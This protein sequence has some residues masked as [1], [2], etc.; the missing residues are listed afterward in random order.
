VPFTLLACNF[1]IPPIRLLSFSGGCGGG[2]EGGWWGWWWGG[3]G[4]GVGVEVLGG[5]GGSV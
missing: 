2:R 3:W 4:G 5:V 1:Y